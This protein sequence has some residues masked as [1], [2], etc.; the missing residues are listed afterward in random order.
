[1]YGFPQSWKIQKV[2]CR[3]DLNSWFSNTWLFD[4]KKKIFTYPIICCH[5]WKCGRA[6]FKEYANFSNFDFFF[7]LS[8]HNPRVSR[9]SLWWHA[10]LYFEGEFK[11]KWYDWLNRSVLPARCV[12]VKIRGIQ[13]KHRCPFCIKVAEQFFT[14]TSNTTTV[15]ATQ[16]F[17]FKTQ[18]HYIK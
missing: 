9:L 17:F 14:Q 3:K 1:M 10:C 4:S 12:I 18:S 8:I 13:V 16:V 6:W 11:W 15:D 2:C 5:C 7:L